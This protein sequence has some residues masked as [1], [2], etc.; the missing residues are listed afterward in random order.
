MSNY[1]VIGPLAL[2]KDANGKVHYYYQDAV[3]PQEID[4]DQR[5][6]LLDSG[7][8]AE[9]DDDGKIIKRESKRAAE[10]KPV[11]RPTRVAPHSAWVDFAVSKGLDRKT[12]EG[13][14]KADLIEK[15]PA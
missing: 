4:D 13:M 6:R 8:V 5:D 3:I 11:E 7:L 9:V 1:Q 10:D 2:V 12:A 15:Y 14:S